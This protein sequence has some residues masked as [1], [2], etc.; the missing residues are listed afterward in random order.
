[1]ALAIVFATLVFLFVFVASKMLL[2][3]ATNPTLCIATLFAFLA[4]ALY[5]E[6][7]QF[8]NMNELQACKE[9]SAKH[10]Q[11]EHSLFLCFKEQSALPPLQQLQLDK[12]VARLNELHGQDLQ[13]SFNANWLWPCLSLLLLATFAVY[14]WP[15]TAHH[16]APKQVVYYPDGS[17]METQTEVGQRRRP[18]SLTGLIASI[19]PPAYTALSSFVETRT[20]F[21]VPEGST[22]TWKISLDQPIDQAFRLNAAKGKALLST[23]NDKDFALRSQLHQNALFQ[24]TF[25]NE[26]GTLLSDLY[27]IRVIPDQKP[28]LS[29]EQ[30]KQHLSLDWS[31]LQTVQLKAQ[32]K[33]D[34][35]ITEAFLMATVS[36]GEGESVKFREQKL[37]LQVEKLEARQWKLRKNL[38]LS[39]LQMEPGDELYYYIEAI[40]N[41]APQAQKGRS[42]VHFIAINDTAALVA[43]E[44][45]G[46]SIKGMPAYFR[47]QRQIINDTETLIAEARDNE[48]KKLCKG[49]AE[50]QKILRLRYGKFLG[51]E[52]ETVIG[53]SHASGHTESSEEDDHSEHD[54]S[55]HD[56][57]EHDHS[58]HDHSEHDHSEHDH[59]EHDHSAHDHSEHDH[60]DHDH[61]AHDHSAHDHSDHEQVE[62]SHDAHDHASHDHAGHDHGHDHG[63]E[64]KEEPQP[65]GGFGRDTGMFKEYAHMHD[66]PEAATFF[67]Q[68]VKKKLKAA[69]A[70]MWESELQLR[71]NRPKESLPYQHK[72]LQLIKEVQQQSRIFV[73]KVGFQP[74]PI[75]ESKKRYSGELG[76]IQSPQNS[77]AIIQNLHYSGAAELLLALETGM[78]K[79]QI[80]TD[81]LQSAA[82]DFATALLAQEAD[83]FAAL[84]SIRL[85]LSQEKNCPDCWSHILSGLH[86]IVELPA[87]SKSNESVQDM[88]LLRN[89]YFNLYR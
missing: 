57:S 54:H 65:T 17:L 44:V 79:T 32:A 4:A 39:A 7:M 43:S 89:Y 6:Q 66:N 14:S 60:S 75:D 45:E 35:Q 85:L 51:E 36:R 77:S 74:P 64:D 61:S 42:D 28:Q 48:F 59:A 25:E 73:H 62:E 58:E 38:D 72:A 21:A 53:H 10:Q 76:K 31:D 13:L 78:E 18:P 86:Q 81:L 20:S 19:Q 68:S 16:E 2:S 34:Y 69:L 24:F 33:D 3:L 55:A 88:D 27:E 40:D 50:D 56:H 23:T 67:E 82:Q 46:M 15:K 80:S 41:R 26:N 8:R 11:L 84:K 12:T 1:M 5:L 87:L 9:L 29:I 52:Y 49:L 83:L 71:L 30:P 37:A 47:S 22:V 63:E 70:Q